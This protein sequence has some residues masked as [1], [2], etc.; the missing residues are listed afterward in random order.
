MTATDD[1][2]LAQSALL[3]ID[4]Q[5]SFRATPRWDRRSNLAFEANVAALVDAY[6]AAGLPVLYFLHTDGDAG[7]APDSPHFKLMDFL[8]P[9]ADEPVLVKSTRNCFTSTD[10]QPRLLARG[11]RRVAIAGIQTEQC[12]E[13]TARVAADLGFA[14]DFAIDATM[15]FPIPNWDAPGEEL[16]VEAIVERTA[17]ALRRRFAR[18]V[19]AADLAAEVSALAEAPAAAGVAA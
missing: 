2:P 1:V 13:T 16:A 7:F 10:L 14:V 8:A 17:Y 11:V 19:R 4:A 5:D 6:H 9:R 3:V 12:C 15:T 18:V